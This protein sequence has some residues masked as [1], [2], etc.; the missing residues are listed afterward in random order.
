MTV[1]AGSAPR[2]KKK[3]RWQQREEIG[4]G[5]RERSLPRLVEQQLDRRE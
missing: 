5:F 1:S 3:G 2:I 4:G